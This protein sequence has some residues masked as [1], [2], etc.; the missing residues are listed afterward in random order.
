[1][2]TGTGLRSRLQRLMMR[3]LFVFRGSFPEENLT[4][5]H[6]HSIFVH[7]FR[8]HLHTTK[9]FD[10][11]RPS[12]SGVPWAISGPLTPETARSKSLQKQGRTCITLSTTSSTTSIGNESDTISSP[13]TVACT[14]PSA[15]SLSTGGLEDCQVHVRGGRAGAAV[16]Y[17]SPYI[18]ACR[19][20]NGAGHILCLVA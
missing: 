5:V 1:M 13:D 12:I 10:Q 15:R 8:R 7:H 3:S 2:L 4:Y 16:A 17:Q 19:R 18:S 6:V 14:G 20:A 11:I 9:A